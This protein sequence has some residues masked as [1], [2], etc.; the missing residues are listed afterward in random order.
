[1]K[2]HP[3]SLVIDA[4]IMRRN[5]YSY[6]EIAKALRVGYATVRDWVKYRTRCA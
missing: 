6:G 2:A 4:L 5:G 3:K 1:M